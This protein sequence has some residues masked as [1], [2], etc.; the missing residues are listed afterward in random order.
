MTKKKRTARTRLSRGVFVSLCLV[1]T[2]VLAVGTGIFSQRA[3]EQ[4]VLS[5]NSGT[6]LSE[7]VAEVNIA[8]EEQPEPLEITSDA[9]YGDYEKGKVLVAVDE[10]T[11]MQ[12]LDEVLATSDLVET[13]SVSDQD[14]SGG[15]VR[16]DINGDVP[17]KQILSEL[18]GEGFA[19][20]PNYIY[21]PAEDE[22]TSSAVSVNDPSSSKQWLLESVD[23]YRAWEIAKCKEDTASSPKVSVAVIDTGCL[24]A[25]E[26]LI[27]NIRAVYN[28]ATSELGVDKVADSI[29]HGT[30]V[31]G[32]V[33]ADANNGKGVAGVSYD[34]G[35][36]IV[37]ASIGDTKSFSTETLAQAYT[38]LMTNSGAQTN[39]QR[40]NVRVINMSVGGKGSIDSDDVLYQKITQ[41]KN[42]GIL[43]V[44]A[45]GNAD[46]GATPPFDCIPGD[47]KDCFT[48][49]N[50]AQG[51]NAQ[52]NDS[53]GTSYVTRSNTSNY[54][55]SSGELSQ[56]K[57]ISAPGAKIYS[58]YNGGTSSYGSL[59][60]TSMASP[61][62]A[63]IAA[64]LFAYDS[65]LSADEVREVL[66]QTAT[67]IGAEGWDRETGY[68][69]IDAYHA[70]QVLSAEIANDQVMGEQPVELEVQGADGIAADASEWQWESSDPNIL[71]VDNT[72]GTATAIGSGTATLT[73]THKKLASRTL[74]KQ[75]SVDAAGLEEKIDLSDSS[76]ISASIDLG[77]AFVYTGQEARPSVTVKTKDG[78]T[79]KEG[80]DYTLEYANNISASVNTVNKKARVVVMASSTSGVYT[81]SVELYFTIDQA[82]IG[83]ATIDPIAD[84]KYTGSAIAPTPVV[85]VNGS[86]LSAID[87][88]VSYKNN[89]NVGTATLV[90]TGKGNYKGTKEATFKIAQDQGSTSTSSSTEGQSKV[91]TVPATYTYNPTTHPQTLTA[92]VT[93]DSNFIKGQKARFTYNIS[94]NTRP[95]VYKLN[96]FE[97]E[98][99]SGWSPLVDIT[100][101]EYGSFNTKNYFEEALYTPGNYRL[102]F[103]VA[104]YTANA[105]GTKTLGD[106]QRFQINFTVAESDNFKSIETIVAEVVAQCEQ[107][108]ANSKGTSSYDYDRALWLNDWLV[109]NTKYDSSLMYCSAEGV[110]NRG[111]GTCEGYH[112]AYAMLLNKAGIETRRVDDF[113]DA[114]VWTGIK[115]NGNWYNVDTTWND[116]GYTMPDLDLQRLYFALP[117]GII[118]K[119]HPK[120]DGQYSIKYP[121]RATF[122]ANS[123]ADNYFIH[124]GEIAQYVSPYTAESG[125][126]SV[127]SKLASKVTS[128]DLPVEK[129]S[130]PDNYKN[131]IYSL[132][133]YQLGTQNWGDGIKVNVGYSDG[134]LHFQATYDG[135]TPSVS[136]TDAV[137]MDLDNQ[138]YSGSALTPKPTV[139]LG[140][141][142]LVEGTD[143]QLS[144]ENNVNASVLDKTKP[145]AVIIQGKGAYSGS[146]KKTFTIDQ[147]EVYYAAVAAISA[148]QYTGSALTPKPTIT[149]GGRTL[150]TSDYSISYKNNT[151]VGT[152]T[153]TIT[154]KGNYKGTKE[155]TFKINAKTLPSNPVLSATSYIYDGKAKTPGVTVKDGTKT[156]VNGTDYSVKYSNNV[157]VGTATVT[158]TGKGNYTGSKSTNFK[159]NAAPVGKSIAS[160]TVTTSQMIRNANGNVIVPSITVKYGSITLKN[161]TDYS[162]E[163]Y[164]NGKGSP[165]SPKAAG[166]YTIK[167]KGKGN[168]SGETI[169]K[170]TFKLVQG[171]SASS[172]TQVKIAPIANLNYV[173]D[174][175]ANPPKIGANVSIWNDNGGNNQKWYLELG[176]DGYYTIKSATN[177]SFIIDAAA[178]PPKIGSNVSIWTTKNQNNQKWVIEPS[179]NGSYI[180]RN[181]ANPSLVLDAAGASPKCGANVSVWSAKSQNNNNQKWKIITVDTPPFDANKTYEI[182]SL[183]NSSF[184][185][186]A[187]ANPPK[188]GAN[189]SI[190]T[191]KNQANQK[192][193]IQKD[194]QGYYTIRSAANKSFILDAAANPPRAGSN[195][196]IW[197]SKNQANQKWIIEQLAN[198][199]YIIKSVGNS[200]LVLDATGAT[201]K[202][203]ANVSVW[204]A[205]GGNNQ[206]WNI[207]PA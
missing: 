167:V 108:C 33:A 164:L 191:K 206:K 126:Y 147:A 61:A 165:V 202:I 50:L 170:D 105:D 3:L 132:V 55:V 127:K 197:T 48:V 178:N 196:S 81:G 144:Y 177:K 100:R 121:D 190:W 180:I 203:G 137:V 31:A 40:N 102:S 134:S 72:A 71:A 171:P 60:G 70:L 52:P 160:A 78:K 106:M 103:L 172:S 91:I 74:S 131:V 101:G 30:H 174:A 187:A 152:A 113:G 34:A 207:K 41:A 90:V 158:V 193:Y 109:E 148:Q 163:Y 82:D 175:V 111:L 195:V 189:V 186:D 182:S 21:Y 173:L 67:D 162:V 124:S 57:N 154:G 156:L 199:S 17:I 87:Y 14:I 15:F 47:Y 26:D 39:A 24:V 68:G 89:I 179:T 86:T 161:G 28:S 93:Y 4:Q 183:S 35:L 69:E 110:F 184:V 138:T 122:D 45:A 83:S 63:G 85:K 56:A 92:T 32:I 66:E 96:S 9:E 13:K 29:G 205:N 130:W 94:G 73:A 201:P 181:A 200:K 185:L 112:E 77:Q 150:T 37:K 116:A 143:Y 18:K 38:W 133:A 142:T 141:K 80:T 95:L 194:S 54:N 153:V 51:S 157:N 155:T 149:L 115:L 19:A 62:V 107:E 16:V 168:Y 42:A 25:H 36:V 159:I 7:S 76:A 204:T 2:I 136:L 198:G 84:Q 151:N 79:L 88:T 188:I 97:I 53:S 140:G 145:A 104:E 120:W 65:S 139:V 27:N 146:L 128:F 1:A 58:T 22:V 46:A 118:Q 117:S 123:F 10:T 49:I 169:A 44:C 125:S 8:E 64:L 43:T 99:S 23:A 11:D 166:S 5:D 192:W 114:H 98:T 129:S 176:N 6:N 119:V 135:S 75:M 20:Q 12:H 59:S